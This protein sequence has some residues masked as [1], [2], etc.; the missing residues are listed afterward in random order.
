[1]DNKINDPVFY[2]FDRI[3]KIPRQSHNEE[4]I[5]EYLYNWAKEQ[6]LDV[7]RDNYNNIFIRVPATKGY[8]NKDSIALQAHMDMVCEKNPEIEHDFSK[9]PIEYFIDGD[10]VSTHNRTTLGADDG[11]GVATILALIKSDNPHPEL[12]IIFTTDEEDDFT[13]ASNFNY[14]L[15]KSKYL[16]NVDHAKEDEIICSSAGGTGIKLVKKINLKSKP[17]K[18][19]FKTYRISI[20]GFNG[21]HSGED[22]EKGYGNA[23][24]ELF[25][26]INKL[27]INY[28]V[29]NINGGTLR[30]A[31]PR[32][33]SI[34][35]AFDPKDFKNV[36]LFLEEYKKI[37]SD[38]YEYLNDNFDID[39]FEIENNYNKII[40]YKDFED[41]NKIILMLPNGI[42]EMSYTFKNTVKTSINIGEVR[43]NKD[44]LEIVA[45]IRSLCDSETQFLIDKIEIISELFSYQCTTFST[46]CAWK[47]KKNSKLKDIAVEIFEKIQ[48]KK[49]RAIALHAGLECSFFANVKDDI[50][51]I[52][53]GPNCRYFH[54][55]KEEFEFSSMQKIYRC[56][57]ELVKNI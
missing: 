26:I 23:N 45:E 9:D 10:I 43:L 44:T 16:I 24:I 33:A 36:K 13:G 31:I 50:D 20:K 19:N 53:I 47:F 15:I 35:L 21:G 29:L 25:R 57:A 37:I 32:E 39:I 8:E 22:I 18:N 41:L 5:S 52:S 7:I 1:M 34:D 49:I 42:Q 54:S 28:E 12:E 11:I 55:P 6:N 38:E 4:L 17:E 14:E 3:T 56:L 46:Y 40:S 30:T 48:K 2:E 27:Y 51:I